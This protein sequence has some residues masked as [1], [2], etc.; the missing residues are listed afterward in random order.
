DYVLAHTPGNTV[1]NLSSTKALKDVTEKYGCMH[2]SAAVG[3]VNV[4]EEMKLREAV[5]GGEGNGGVIY[6]ALHYGRD[7]L[8]GIALFLSHLAKSK[9]KVSELRNIYPYYVI[10]KK[11][12]SLSPGDEFSSIIEAVKKNFPDSAT[13]ERD[14]LW[15]DHPLGWVQIRKSNTEPIMRI[16][17]E[18]K[19]SEDAD[20]LA[21]TVIGIVKKS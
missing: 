6:P 5:I 2:F 12:L 16:Y 7:A 3:E 11:K 17:A 1:S 8:A 18:G 20:N 15:I 19:T 21:D 4:V 13:D 14:G 10:A 9:K